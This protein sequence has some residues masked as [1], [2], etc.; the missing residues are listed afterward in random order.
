MFIH[1]WT[2]AFALC[3]AVYGAVNT[4]SIGH[5][6]DKV[7]E[8]ENQVEGLIELSAATAARQIAHDGGDWPDTNEVWSNAEP[9]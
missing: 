3:V 9:K 6:Q 5:L 7:R 8:L 4:W 2:F 1:D